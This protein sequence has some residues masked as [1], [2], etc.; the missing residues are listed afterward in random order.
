MYYKSSK[1]LCAQYSEG[2]EMEPKER[3]YYLIIMTWLCL[4]SIILE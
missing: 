2:V 3:E 1:E 4:A